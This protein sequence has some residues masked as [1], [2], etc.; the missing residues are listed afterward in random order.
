MTNEEISKL[1]DE[2]IHLKA[3]RDQRIAKLMKN[4]LI[5]R[6]NE[7]KC[8]AFGTFYT[9][10]VVRVYNINKDLTGDQ[11]HR[12]MLHANTCLS[13]YHV[14]GFDLNKIL[15]VLYKDNPEFIQDYIN[16]YTINGVLKPIKK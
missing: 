10:E 14:I 11:L 13:R 9:R 5:K 4:K 3:D 8:K 7:A 2:A 1:V 15:A 6:D 16:E 12:I